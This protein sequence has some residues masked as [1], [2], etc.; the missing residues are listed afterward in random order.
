M[1]TTTKLTLHNHQKDSVSDIVI[2]PWGREYCAYRNAEVAIWALEIEKG[3]ATSLHCHPKKNTAL[4]VLQGEVELSFIRD[5]YPHRLIGLDKINI[6]RGRFH[7]TRAVSDNVVLLEVEA[8]DDKRDILRI[9]DDYNRVNKPIEEATQPLDHNCLQI[10]R[11]G[12]VVH[13]FAKCRLGVI[14]LTNPCVLKKNDVLVTLSGGLNH[15]LVP[16]GDAIDGE[17]L[18]RFSC[19]FGRLPNTTFLQIWKI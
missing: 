3:K 11:S 9:D 12:D 14:T 19:S 4:I 7:R 17:T 1:A 8:P 10:V 5:A 15:G 13:Q 2:K 16:P 6:F 18:A